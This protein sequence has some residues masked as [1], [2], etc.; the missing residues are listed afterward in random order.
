MFSVPRKNS[1]NQKYH[2]KEHSKVTEPAQQRNKDFE[3]NVPLNC[4]QFYVYCL[5]LHFFFNFYMSQCDTCICLRLKHSC[6]Y[7]SCQYY[8]FLCKMLMFKN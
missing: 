8:I 4:K 7:N 3:G 6:H 2:K 1:G 5:L